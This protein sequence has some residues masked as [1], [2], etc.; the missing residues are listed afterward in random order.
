MFRRDRVD[1]GGQFTNEDVDITSTFKAILDLENVEVGWMN[2]NTG[3][4]PDFSLVPM[5]V[6][7][8]G[9]PSQNHKN[10]VRSHAEALE[11][12][13]RRQA[14]PRTGVGRQGVPVRI[15]ELYL[16]Y[17]AAKGDNPG[18]L[19]VVVLKTTPIKSGSG[20]KTSTNYRPKFEIVSWAARGDL[21]FQPKSSEGQKP[22][23]ASLSPSACLRP[24]RRS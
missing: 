11:R 20:E 12:V 19:P 23:P 22:L 13:R 4:A 17:Q 14:H 6:A 9:R 24:A 8:P 15:E 5:G 16:A 3:G 2:F 10:G 7:L 21:V 1:V 18:K